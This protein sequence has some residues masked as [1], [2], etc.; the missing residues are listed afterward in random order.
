MAVF[1][2]S[3]SLLKEINKVMRNFWWGQIENER[4][5]HWISWNSMGKSKDAGGLVFKDLHSFK[6]ATLAKQGWKLLHHPQALASHV[7]KTK[8]FL[9]GDFFQAKSRSKPSFIWRSILAA[10]ELL[11]NGTRWRVG[12]GECIKTWKD[13]WI[14]RLSSYKVKSPMSS[15]GPEATASILIDST[16]KQWK[17]SMVEEMI[18]LKEARLIKQIPIRYNNRSNKLIWI[19]SAQGSFYVRSAFQL[20]K[21][22]MDAKRGDLMVELDAAGGKE[23]VEEFTVV[24]KGVWM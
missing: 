14:P 10:R 15:L 20:H 4:K 24:A 23:L 18:S 1:K 22:I 16:T 12:N 19:G 17:T 3:W 11:N 7:L 6:L 2:L 13:K 9:H 5:I 8:Y 21:E